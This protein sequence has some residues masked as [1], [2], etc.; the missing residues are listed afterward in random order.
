[1]TFRQLLNPC[2]VVEP[3]PFGAQRRDGV[4][5][6]PDLRTQLGDLLGPLGGFKL[7]LVDIGRRHEEP[8][9]HADVDE[10]DHRRLAL[11]TSASDGSRGSKSSAPRR[12][13]ASVRSAARS[14]AERARGLAAISASSGVTG[15][16]VKM[17]NEGAGSIT[18]G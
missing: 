18:S 3:R 8:R 16:P 12:G 7:D 2:G 11:M 9:N 1:M 15:R 17:R 6:A 14:L 4:V 10:A 5:L 13:G